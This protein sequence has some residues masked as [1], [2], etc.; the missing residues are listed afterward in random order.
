MGKE[1]YE[2][3]MKLLNGEETDFQVDVDVF[4]ITID[5]VADYLDGWQ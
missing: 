5:N 3:A 2:V 1:C 4:S